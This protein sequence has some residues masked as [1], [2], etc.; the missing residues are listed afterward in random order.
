MS[1]QQDQS[2]S[3]RNWIELAF[4]TGPVGAGI[5]AY[6]RVLGGAIVALPL[7]LHGFS[8]LRHQ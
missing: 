7:L 3:G 6:D 5:A 1:N 2:S 8:W 4:L